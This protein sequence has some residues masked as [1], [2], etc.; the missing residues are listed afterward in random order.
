VIGPELQVR[1][2]AENK[3]DCSIPRS[4]LY[5]VYNTSQ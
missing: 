5:T 1:F 3:H 4:I 2:A